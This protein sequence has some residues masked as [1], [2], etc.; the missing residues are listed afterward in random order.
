MNVLN[1]EIEFRHFHLFCGL[2][3]GAKG[4]NKGH[5]RVGSLNANW[6]CIG[7][8]DVDPASIRDFS[9]AAKVQGTMLDM[10][11][12]EQFVAFHGKEPPAGWREATPADIRNAAHG[13]RP[14]AV[15][16]SAP[17][18]GFSGLL[19]EASS[20]TD[21]YQ[22]LN[23]LTLRGVWLM[24]EAWQDDPPEL[25]VFENVPRIAKRGR[26]LLDQIVALL[27]SYGYA[28][29]E[30]THDCGELGGLGQS[31]KRFLL[32]GRHESKVP[33]FLYEPEKR[34]L[35][36]VGE[37]LERLP[38]PGDLTAGP[39]HRMPA[40]QWK[41]W[42]R[43]AF[44][45]A[46]SDWRSLNKLAVAD[47]VLR[48]FGILPDIEWQSGVLGVN[49]WQDP[50]GVVA[51]RSGPTNGAFAV[52]DPTPSNF[53]DD[54]S[55]LLGVGTSEEPASL[56]RGQ[57]SPQQGRFSVADPRVDGHEKS[58]QLGVRK[59]DQTAACVKGDVS[60]GTGPY[61]VS[62]P[63]MEGKPRFNNTFRIV[64]W[65]ERSPAVAGPGG[66]AGGLAVA[67][68]RPSQRDDY[69]QTKYRVTSLDEAA[70]AV[71]GASTTG[72][73]AFAVADPALNWGENAHGSKLA[74]QGWEDP[75]RTVTSSRILA[76]GG[77]V[78]DPR[79]A[80][81]LHSAALGVRAWEEPSGTVQGESFP[82]NGSF[83]VADP[84]PVGL[85][86]N[87]ENYKT[88]GHYGVIPW[89][90][91]GYA[92]PGFAKYDRGHWS[93]ADPRETAAEPLFELPQ[94]ADRLVAVIRALDNTWHRPFTTLELAALQS[95]VDPDDLDGFKL[96]GQSDS[97]WRERIGNAVPP[98]A[99]AAIAS[100]MATTLLL[101]MTGETFMLSSQP[102]WVR[103]VAVA[104]AVDDRGNIPLEDFSS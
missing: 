96:D 10:F 3:G 41:T 18:K 78:A 97:A 50:A 1:T 43:L 57:R 55:G 84:R 76:G 42:V 32:V 48:D 51:G 64:P 6:R 28:V 68:P 47:G 87:R 29:R 100:V 67:D 92:V 19:P 33:P 72:N 91:V 63:R 25:I 22:A 65:D 31:R 94:P 90:G 81:D 40:L 70:G 101:A 30:T 54:R 79:P 38:R 36:G 85:N 71:I 37:I 77:A 53:P 86:A 74:V 16:L 34:R 104:L 2:G 20:I 58:V 80:D 69:K 5:A 60:V 26:F 46:G 93:V 13:E 52:A 11:S 73:G 75:A 24:L 99:A 59:W 83:A 88:G 9:R 44:V 17:C 98:D 7:G 62:D 102:I 39:M 82:T 35:R 66:P 95:L 61:A 21:K 89:G 45:E 56:V 27:R 15:F 14:N 4:F 12:R 23:G 8:V 49:R 103:D